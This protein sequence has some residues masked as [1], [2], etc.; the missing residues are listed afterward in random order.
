M[1]HW[2][3]QTNYTQVQGVTKVF[4]PCIASSKVSFLVNHTTQKIYTNSI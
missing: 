4:L 1:L 3:E 2:D